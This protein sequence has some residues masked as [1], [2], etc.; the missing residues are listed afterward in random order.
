M[1]NNPILAVSDVNKKGNPIWFDGEESFV[2]P[3]SAN[4]LKEIRRLIAKVTK[5]IQLHLSNGTFK[6]KSWDL[7]TNPFQGQGW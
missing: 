7:P 5:K 4:E 1:W 2:I 3:G 6:L